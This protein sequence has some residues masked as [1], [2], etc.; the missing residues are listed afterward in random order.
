MS[1]SPINFGMM[2][3]MGGA[4]SNMMS[5]AYGN[6]SDEDLRSQY[7][8]YSSMNPMMGA[9]SMLMSQRNAMQA[10][11][12]RRQ[13]LGDFG[14]PQDP[15]AAAAEN[16]GMQAAQAANTGGAVSNIASGLLEGGNSCAG[17]AVGNAPIAT[18]GN[19]NPQTQFAAG[20]MFGPQKFNKKPLINL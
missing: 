3:G 16:A 17:M 7:D 15:A 18:A 11:I 12:Q 10:E 5:G 20:N 4:M 9:N 8:A 13:S 2:S 6:M 14:M 1:K 19:F